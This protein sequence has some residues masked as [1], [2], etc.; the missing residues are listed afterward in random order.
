MSANP[1][2]MN[3]RNLFSDSP[4]IR[5]TYYRARIT[6]I[7]IPNDLCNGTEWDKLSQKIW[8]KFEERRQPREV[9]EKKMSLWNNLCKAVEVG[10]LHTSHFRFM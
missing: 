7:N 2:T 10:I 9:F 5:E 3:E 6:E 1:M 8:A 4:K